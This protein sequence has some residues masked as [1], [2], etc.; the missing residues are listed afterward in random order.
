MKK[1]LLFTLLLFSAISLYGQTGKLTGTITDA[2]TGEALIGVN[3]IVEG[4]MYGAA[5]DIDGF[6]SII[7]ISPGKYSLKASY[8][9]YTPS[10]MTNVVVN[11]NET[12][13]I[14]F[15]LSDEAVTTAE[16]VVAAAKI[17]IVQQD[18]SSSRA[19]ITS[20]EIA[21]LPTVN[22]NSVL[23]LQAG[24]ETTSEG[25]V[26][27]GSDVRETAYVLNG[28]TLRNERDNT[29]FTGVSVTA[30]ENMQVQTGG[31]NAEY[32][33]F[34]AGLVNIVTM[35]GR[36][37]Q[38]TF[39]MVG[40]YSPAQ[41][42]HFGISPHDPNSYWV[43]SYVDDAVAWTGT[44]NGNWDEFTQRQYAEF[45]GW[46]SI[47]RKT[48]EDDDP[49]NDLTPQA[50]QN[51]YLWE[52]RRQ[53]DIVDPDYEMDMTFAG[54]VPGGK[55][56]GDLRFVASYRQTTEQYLVPLSVPN[57]NDWSTQFKIT[58]DLAQ[59][60]KLSVDGIYGIRRGTNDNNGG[61][62]GVFKSSSS[63]AYQLSR[64]SYIDT[65]MFATDYWAPST[66]INNSIGA[67]FTHVVNPT[68]FYD[69]RIS[70]FGSSYETNP[71]TARDTT[72]IKMFGNSYWVDEAPFGF[73][74][75]PSFGIDGMRMGVGMS[76][77]RDSSEVA[78]YSLKFDFT[79]Q[80]D[81]FNQIKAGI[82]FNYTLNQTNYASVDEFLPQGRSQSKWDSKP[83]RGAFYIQDK[84][85][86]EGMIANLGVRM[87]YF[88]PGGEWWV[89]EP[90]T[91]AF[92]AVNS[93]GMDTLLTKE[94]TEKQITFSPRVGIA[95]PITVNS[96]LYF[97]YGH[98][99]SFPTPEN[100]YL[101]RK[102]S[103]DQAVLRVATPNNPLERT[104]QYELGYEHNLF[105]QFLLRVAGYYKDISDQPYLV[106]YINRDGDIDYR[107]SEPNSYAD[108]RG[109]EFTIS[110]NRGE[111]FQGFFNY[112]Y[113]VSTSGNFGWS[114]Q[115]ENPTEQLDYERTS[116][117]EKQSKPVPRPYAK[118]NLNF[119]SPSSLGILLGDWRLN[120]IGGW[121][122]GFYLT[123]TG[124]GAI[125]GILYNVQ[126]KD[127]YTMDLRFSKSINISDVAQI[128]FIMD[129]SNLFNFKNM[130]SRYG[131]VDGN[132]YNEYMKS[133]H[134]P[135]DVG[136][137][138]SGSYI[139]IPGD[140]T[141]G[142]YRSSG[143]FTPIVPVPD[144]NSVSEPSDAA[145]YWDKTTQR[146]FEHDGNQWVRVDEGKM[147]TII[148]NK[149]YIDMPNQEFFSFLNPRKIYF[150]LK[151]SI[152]F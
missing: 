33:D 31:F 65:R 105:D 26:V 44:K 134:L 63:I 116:G 57:Y 121:N 5:T 125:P 115:F 41:Q 130:S 102:N 145:I 32:G 1:F 15:Q 110:K 120:L 106:R 132:D 45:E 68:T 77:S 51:L 52:H 87:D 152:K 140:D 76:N 75:A 46:N 61:A 114:R 88:D 148:Q 133:L 14:D 54:P 150:G 53:L 80:V 21:N 11:I 81:K 79:S 142:D 7:S 12:T 127:S 82:D 92:S 111:W 146:Y 20:D 40:R 137:E 8:I 59:G 24:I 141:P 42:K 73:Q 30:I 72:K 9:G 128:E 117:D 83:V 131:F 124:G 64:L 60:M 108:I 147:H 109:A 47:S 86:F 139:N 58:S 35:E 6:F 37:N 98:M 143:E 119:F 138:L 38:Y 29:P 22:I 27:R 70:R 122:N 90:W 49:N 55:A 118:I 36:R 74:P 28:M 3:V 99:R 48:L 112:T 107:V 19:N 101:L 4:T 23:G 50:A 149:Q 126:W 96:K 123:W 113:D 84:L 10:V 17:P 104:V 34:R 100:L 151:L 85:E 136:D 18:V 43:R 129:V 13:N 69:I 66:I 94:R 89:Y 67:K 16:V 62:G 39:N 25:V 91:G 144:I 135:S 93:P 95:F 56:L 103:F 97:N 78:T 2:K 71:G